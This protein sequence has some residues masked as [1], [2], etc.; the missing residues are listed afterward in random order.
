MKRDYKII[1][2]IYLV[3]DEHELDLHN[4]FDFVGLNYSI[5]NQVLLLKWRRSKGDWVNKN[6]P[7]SLNIEFREVSEFRFSPRDTKIPFTEDGCINSFG[8][9]VDEE[10]AEGVVMVEPNQTPDHDWLTAI[11]FMSG[12]V[13]AV[14]A[15]STHA[16]ITA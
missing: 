15:S 1:D 5:E 3:Q 9:W 8:Y 11:D 10:W 12:A 7:A 2:G 14:Q 4:N 6:T 13:I 16:L